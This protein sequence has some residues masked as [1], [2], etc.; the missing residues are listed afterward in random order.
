MRRLLL[1][2]LRTVGAIALVAALAIALS[3]A[4]RGSHLEPLS[5]GQ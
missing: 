4:T 3:I 1:E 2:G 5:E